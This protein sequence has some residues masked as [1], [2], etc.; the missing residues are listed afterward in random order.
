M[1]ACLILATTVSNSLNG[2]PVD[3]VLLERIQPWRTVRSWARFASSNQIVFSIPSKIKAKDG[4]L[5]GV[6]PIKLLEFY[7]GDLIV[8]VDLISREYIMYSGHRARADM[9][10]LLA[11]C[12]DDQANKVVDTY[13]KEVSKIIVHFLL[14]W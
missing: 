2:I 4:F 11:R 7:L 10:K 1:N 6:F 9:T 5:R 8:R 12:W 3:P 13:F 14:F